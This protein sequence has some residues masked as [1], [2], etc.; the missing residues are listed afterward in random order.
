MNVILTL[1]QNLR[2]QPSAGPCCLIVEDEVHRNSIEVLKECRE[3]LPVA[4]YLVVRPAMNSDAVTRQL[5][6]V[7]IP[8]CDVQ[9][10]T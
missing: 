8:P 2:V 7:R 6:K 4:L 1:L 3:T 5:P 10:D 9:S